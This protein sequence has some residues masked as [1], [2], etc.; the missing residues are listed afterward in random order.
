MSGGSFMNEL[1]DQGHLDPFTKLTGI[2][3]KMVS[4]R[5]QGAMRCKLRANRNDPPF[6]TSIPRSGQRR[7][8]VA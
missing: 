1:A 7:F 6:R 2:K 3:V 4:G 5:H 8:R